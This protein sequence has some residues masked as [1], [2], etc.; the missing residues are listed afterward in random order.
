[1]PGNRLAPGADR[2]FPMGGGLFPGQRPAMGPIGSMN[3][4]YSGLVTGA[5]SRTNSGSVDKNTNR[6]RLLEDFR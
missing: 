4:M 5:K 3:A 6:S 1:M 2:S